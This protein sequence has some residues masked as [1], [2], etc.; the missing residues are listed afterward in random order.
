MAALD[1]DIRV[2]RFF[3]NEGLDL[4]EEVGERDVLYLE[5]FDGDAD[6]QVDGAPRAFDVLIADQ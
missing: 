3:L 4:I 6:G 2:V 1:G 5:D